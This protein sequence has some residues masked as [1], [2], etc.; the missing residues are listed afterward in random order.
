MT[1][2]KLKEKYNTSF[3]MTLSVIPQGIIRVGD[4]ITDQ[5]G[6]IYTVKSVMHPT[7]PPLPDDQSVCVVVK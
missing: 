1:K 7:R 2:V 3:G 5:T 4:L 6:S